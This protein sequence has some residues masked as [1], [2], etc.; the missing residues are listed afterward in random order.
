M[1]SLAESAPSCGQVG[2]G[3]SFMGAGVLW[4]PGSDVVHRER[5]GCSLCIGVMKIRSD[6]IR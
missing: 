1:I 2:V 6:M 5:L 3:K 4:D